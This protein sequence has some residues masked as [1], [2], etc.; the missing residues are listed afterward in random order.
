M[1]YSKL[2]V[3]YFDRADGATS[4]NTFTT[5][6]SG[7]AGAAAESQTADNPFAAGFA[8][9]GKGMT[10]EEAEQAYQIS[11]QNASQASTQNTAQDPALDPTQN[12]AQESAQDPT[13]NTAQESAQDPTQNTAQE[14]AQDLT[15]NTTQ[16][17]SNPLVIPSGR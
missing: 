14:S 13:Q 15:Q 2:T 10:P 6:E 9:F 4:L 8:A 12:T 5:E 16:D 1:P 7:D 3:N 17:G 11:M